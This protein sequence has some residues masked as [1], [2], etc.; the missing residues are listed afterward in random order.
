MSER[1]SFGS[2]GLEPSRV[3]MFLGTWTAME[4]TLSLL[5]PLTPGAAGIHWPALSTIGDLL[6][7]EGLSQRRK[8]RRRAT[9]TPGGVPPIVAPNEVWC[10]DFKGLVPHRGWR[11]VLSTDRDRRVQPLP[12][13]L[14]CDRARL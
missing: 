6:Q 12:A 10:V 8:R 11:H 13:V 14:P 9:P 1:W 2:V 3:S 5:V 4:W 7:R